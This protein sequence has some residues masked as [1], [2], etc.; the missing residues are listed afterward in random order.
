MPYLQFFIKISSLHIKTIKY[1]ALRH[2]YF[3]TNILNRIKYIKQKAKEAIKL[4]DEH[5]LYRCH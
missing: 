3:M 1:S 4:L 2:E 5:F